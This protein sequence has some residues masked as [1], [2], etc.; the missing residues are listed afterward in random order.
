M[1]IV[2]YLRIGL[3]DQG[4]DVELTRSTDDFV[5]LDA[6][7]IF[8]NE[9][10][11]DVFISIHCNAFSDP[12]A[13]GYE[14]WTSRGVTDA[15]AIAERLF[16]SI[17]ASFPRLTGRADHTD[18]DSDKEAGFAVLVGTA[19]PAVLIETAFIS[20]LMEERWLNDVGWKMRMA[21][22]IVSGLRN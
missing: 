17:G 16:E 2:R 3:V 18:G 14:V 22:A 4:V 19:M 13:H 15:D 1:E 20:N 11:A 7:C 10:L 9:W 5:S 21:G 8:A 12:A 6:R